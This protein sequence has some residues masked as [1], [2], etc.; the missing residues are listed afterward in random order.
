MLD[1]LC[2]GGGERGGEGG[3]VVPDLKLVKPEKIGSVMFFPEIIVA[4]EIEVTEDETKQWVRLEMKNLLKPV[5]A[6][7]LTLPAARRLYFTLEVAINAC[8]PNYEAY[9]AEQERKEPNP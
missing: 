8:D 4:D 5:G 2:A 3:V 9:V 6:L 1:R 7:K